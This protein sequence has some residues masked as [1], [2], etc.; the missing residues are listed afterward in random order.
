MPEM[1][2]TTGIT[3]GVLNG[4][5]IGLKIFSSGNVGELPEEINLKEKVEELS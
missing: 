5:K 3:M 1:L 2:K 4:I